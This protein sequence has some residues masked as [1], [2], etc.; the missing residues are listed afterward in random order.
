MVV[1]TFKAYPHLVIA[2]LKVARKV[3]ESTMKAV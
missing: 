1:L 2:E 3:R